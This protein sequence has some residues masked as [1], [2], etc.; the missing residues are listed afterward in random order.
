MTFA[1]PDD[2]GPLGRRETTVLLLSTFLDRTDPSVHHMGMGS[3]LAYHVTFGAYGFWLP[4]DPRG[5]NSD[6]VRAPHLRPFGKA[7]KVTDKRS[8]ASDPHDAAL[9]AAAKRALKYEPVVLNGVQAREVGHAFQ[10]QTKRSGFAIVACA[11]LPMHVH[12]VVLRH[13]YRI[14]QVVNLL[15]GAATRRLA[16]L[17]LH[18]FQHIVECRPSPWERELRKVFLFSADAIEEKIQ[19]VEGNPVKEGKPKQVWS[20]VSGYRSD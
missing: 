14:E 12:L 2:R 9:R 8:H 5:S 4:I 10:I 13:R 15:K 11:I 16:E 1:V 6:Y 3:V 7:T 18:P 19:Y 20:F 17:G